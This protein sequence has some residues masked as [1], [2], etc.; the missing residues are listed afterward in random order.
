VPSL[1][2]VEQVFLASVSEYLDALDRAIVKAKEFADA[3]EDAALIATTALEPV[4][5]MADSIAK[6]F[7]L[8]AD[9]ANDFRD[10]LAGDA[11]AASAAA[12]GIGDLDSR[13]DDLI[14]LGS[15]A[16]S[17]LHDIR[18][19][20]LGVAAASGIAGTAADG[21]AAKTVVAGAA[22]GVATGFWS[23]WGNVIHWVVAGGSEFLAVF[24]PAM[25]AAG[26]AAA[27]MAQ[28]I[29]D[30][31]DHAMAMYTA[32]EA[33]ANVLHQ[34]IGEW[35][36]MKSVLQSAQNAADPR[37]FELLGAGINIAKASAGSFVAE[38][39]QVLG[40]LD[41]FAAKISGE[42]TGALGKQLTGLLSGGAQ[43]LA[44]FGQILGNV[45]HVI[46]NL[47][48]DMPG[49][50][51]VLLDVFAGASKVLEVFTSMPG[52]IITV[53]MAF[54][55]FWRWGG[56]V[57]TIIG[58]VLRWVTLIPAAFGAAAF[59][60]AN[61][62]KALILASV[63]GFMGIVSSIG[64]AITA[65]GVWIAELGLAGAAEGEASAG[66]VAFGT[67]AA[68]AGGEVTAFAATVEA[69]L[70]AMSPFIAFLA[71]AAGVGLG[72]WIY[73]MSEAQ[74]ATEKWAA[75]LNNALASTSDLELLP[76]IA[77]DMSATT[78]KLAGAQDALN[79]AVASGNG[80]VAEAGS[81]FQKVNQVYEA[82]A[83]N[84]HLLTGEQ[85]YLS[86]AQQNVLA[87]A[88][89]LEK[90]YGTTFV[91][92]LAAAQ[93]AGVNLS[94]SI[95]GTGTSADMARLKMA[96]YFAGIQAMGES[97]GMAGHDVTLL[98][99]ASELTATKVGQLN[100]AVDG[101]VQGITG[102]TSALGG[103]QE[104]I[105]NVGKVTITSGDALKGYNATAGLTMSQSAAAMTSFGQVG[106]QVWQNFDSALSGSAEQLAD[107]FRTAGAE[108]AIG[109]AQMSQAMLDI[110]AQFIPFASR[111]RAAQQT[112]VGFAQAQG[113]NVT[114]FGQLEDAAKK[115][116][117][118]EKSLA[119]ITE[120]TTGRMAD[121]NQVAQALGASVG[122]DLVAALNTARIAASGLGQ[123]AQDMAGAWFHAHTV[124]AQVISGFQQT[125][126]A[127]YA[128][129]RN[130]GE[131]KA[132]ADAYAKS[133]GMTQSQINT[134]NGDIDKLIAKLASIHSPP[135]VNI[136]VITD[137]SSTGSSM[138]AAPL[139][140]H[141]AGHP[142]L[143]G[144]TPSADPGPAIV[145]ERGPELV[146]MHGGETVVPHDETARLLAAAALTH[147][148]RG[149]A[150]G[151]GGGGMPITLHAHL[152]INT[153]MDGERVNSVQ[154]TETLTYSR[155][156]PSNNLALRVR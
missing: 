58:N 51:R 45:G 152:T 144:G 130:T 41:N 131:A 32:Q 145:G 75:S 147:R 4:A 96:N 35:V 28:G 92:A 26:G 85:Q 70:A 17:E 115:A 52:I 49:L 104:S 141:G 134:L 81:R 121:M 54:E 146:Y 34:T 19:A 82:A 65:M 22:A 56:L 139:G 91:G 99:I 7:G 153:E 137:Y 88:G 18:D 136:S 53:A 138:G 14:M 155:R 21:M 30:V 79:T 63:G 33:T 48:G 57:A 37:I 36:G 64:K 86:Q 8:A 76:K 127:L 109:S 42:L 31:Y 150:D 5:A 129:D 105:A 122:Q 94:Q 69:T 13:L 119:S 107:W 151:A 15:A 132:A 3:V 47:A 40:I 110:T 6:N 46:V 156:N 84:V 120:D 103:L 126:N 50:A 125:F 27:V 77:D 154:R 108:G 1:D 140:G 11:G 90:T 149:Y 55:E 128:V 101:F 98:G 114:S 60:I 73:K 61:V 133:L 23:R 135:P 2:P 74:T 62:A 83:S 93:L 16:V 68:V 97:A 112:L 111:S 44:E 124:N 123:A 100:Q 113:L 67:A 59:A 29:G 148:A 43:D 102:G 106:S 9:G 116:G 89:Y 24:I 143:A 25:V 142:L 72:I 118:G 80:Y 20:M 12:N 39:V 71:L 66:L 10:A 78:V 117:A 38:G 87:G 95:T